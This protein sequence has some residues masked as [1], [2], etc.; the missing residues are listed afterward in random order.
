MEFKLRRWTEND[1]LDLVQ[2][3]NNRNVSR[4]L[5]D[6][7]PYPY[8]E[9]DG[10]A[11]IA[12]VAAD[13]PLKVFAIEIEGRAV[14]AVGVFP[15]GDVHRLNAELGYWLAE[16]YWGRGI[17]PEAVRQACDYAFRTFGMERIFACPFGVNTASQ[18]V[19]EKAGFSFEARFEGTI[20]KDGERYDE[21]F[22]AIRSE[23]P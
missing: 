17:M 6:A 18:R 14:G 5:T 22:Y 23:K 13:D 11:F 1:L 7:F 8:G 21:I 19:L 10:R 2:Y 15:Q 20:V 4:W 9:A 16:E 12:S 3:A